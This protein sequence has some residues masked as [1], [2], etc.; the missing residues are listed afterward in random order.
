VQQ[1]QGGS[2]N[3]LIVE[4]NDHLVVFDAPIHEG[5]SRFTIDAA[6]AKYPGKPIRYLVLTH[7][8]ND[9]T[10]GARTYVAEGATVIVPAPDKEFFEAVFSAPHK[11]SPDE[12]EKNPRPATIIEVQDRLT[13]SDETGDI[14][15]YNIPNPHALGMLVIHVTRADLMWVAD[16]YAPGRDSTASPGA[17]SLY[18][19]LM[20]L[21]VR[22]ARF[23]GGHG[24]SA[25]W[26]EFE[27]LQR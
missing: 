13:L 14:R 20:R 1:V 25:S 5:Q 11:V 26:Q 6:K 21:G 10:G 12:L 19:A 24:S 23:A 15:L 7:H 18:Q 3:S 27:A 22:P 8:H 2:H 9:H 4:L 17:A 16:Q